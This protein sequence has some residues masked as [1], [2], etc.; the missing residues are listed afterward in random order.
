MKKKISFAKFDAELNTDC[1]DPYNNA[2]LTLTLRM[3]FKQI[4]P[5][6]GADKGTYHDYGDATEPT[7]KIIK[8]TATSW[9]NWKTNFVSSA[10]AFWTGKFWLINDSGSFPFTK[11]TATYYP[12]VWCRFKLVGNESTVAG[13]HHTID[14]V[15]LDPSESWFGSHSTLYDSKDTN[16]VKKATTSAGKKVMQRAHVHE[17]GHLLGLDHVDVGKPHCPAAGDTNA[18]MCY[19]VADADKL[20]VMGSGM[21]LRLE[22]AY[23]WREAL[24]AFALEELMMAAMGNPLLLALGRVSLSMPVASIT[25]VW[26]AKMQRHYPRTE[27]ELRAGTMIT[28]RPKRPL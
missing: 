6:G 3:G 2:E 16:S 27:A 28:A 14:V 10:E 12:N 13:N 1:C 7:R 8:W 20:A 17:V 24:R 25:S 22:N 26:P 21:Q 18:G 15:R 19:G 5:S 11:G 23:P 9:T 4:N